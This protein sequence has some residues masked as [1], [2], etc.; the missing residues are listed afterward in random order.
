MTS[1]E[2]PG[3]ET[4]RRARRKEDDIKTTLAWERT[5]MALLVVAVATAR[6]TWSILGPAALVP[7]AGL[8]VLT[9]WV[10][11]E[12]WRR[13]GADRRDRRHYRAIGGPTLVLAATTAL[14]AATELVH[15]VAR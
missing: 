1:T 11:A 9:L 8:T 10:L 15:M 13:Y 3:D 6:H 4:P 7:V 12:G 14:A 2:H 5:A